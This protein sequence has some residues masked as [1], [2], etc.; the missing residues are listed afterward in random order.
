MSMLRQA[1]IIASGVW[2]GSQT[3]L[4]NRDRNYDVKLWVVH[5]VRDDIEIAYVLD[6]VTGWS[7]GLNEYGIGVVNTALQVKRDEAEKQLANK[8]GKKSKDGE[9]ILKTLL[10]KTLDSAVKVACTFKGGIKGHTFIS[11]LKKTVSIEATTE[12][13]HI[14]KTLSNTKI[15]IRTNH[16]FHYEDAGY[17]HDSDNYHSSVARRDKAIEVLRGLGSPAEIGPALMNNRPKDRNDPNAIVRDTDNMRTSSQMVLDLT[18]KTLLLNLIPEKVEFLGLKDKMPKG[19]TPKI[20]IKVFKYTDVDGDGDV[21]QIE[22]TKMASIE[23]Q[24]QLKTNLLVHKKEIPLCYKLLKKEIEL[25]KTRP[26]DGD[27]TM[28]TVKEANWVDDLISF[29]KGLSPDSKVYVI[30][31]LLT[32]LPA[33][34]SAIAYLLNAITRMIGTTWKIIAEWLNGRAKGE[35]RVPGEEARLKAAI[36]KMPDKEQ[37]ALFKMLTIAYTKAGVPPQKIM[38]I[39]Q[40]AAA[41]TASTGG[42]MS[43]KT[44]ALDR[45]IE[46]LEEDG[47]YEAVAQARRLQ[48]RY[49]A[50]AVGIPK[51][52][53]ADLERCVK[54][55]KDYEGCAGELNAIWS[56]KGGMKLEQKQY[57]AMCGKCKEGAVHTAADEGT[58]VHKAIH[59]TLKSC[60][61]AG[62]SF[63]ECKK[64]VATLPHDMELTQDDYND[65]KK[66]L[67]QASVV[68]AASYQECFKSMMAEMGV[69]SPGELDDEQSKDFFSKVKEQ[70][71]KEGE[72]P[73]ELEAAVIEVEARMSKQQQK[74]M[75]GPKGKK[76]RGKTVWL[77]AERPKRVRTRGGQAWAC[78]MLYVKMPTKHLGIMKRIVGRGS[79]AP[80]KIMMGGKALRIVGDI[81]KEY[82]K[83][84]K[85]YKKAP[86]PAKKAPA[87]KTKKAAGTLPAT[88]G[89]NSPATQKSNHGSLG[90]APIT[91]QS[92]YDLLA[93]PTLNDKLR[94]LKTKRDEA[95]RLGKD[96]LVQSIDAV[97]MKALQK[98]GSSN[99]VVVGE[100]G[101][102]QLVEAGALDKVKE[103]LG[104][105]NRLEFMGFN[106]PPKQFN[107]EL[108]KRSHWMKGWTI[109]D[110]KDLLVPVKPAS[111]YG[112]VFA[113]VYKVYLAGVIF[114]LSFGAAA[115]LPL[116]ATDLVIIGVV[117]GLMPMSPKN[118]KKFMAFV[119]KAFLTANPGRK[120]KAV[121][122]SAMQ[123]LNAIAMHPDTQT[124]AIYA[125]GTDMDPWKG[126]ERPAVAS[127]EVNALVFDVLA[128]KKAKV[129]FNHLRSKGTEALKTEYLRARMQFLTYRKPGNKYY[130]I[131]FRRLCTEAKYPVDDWDKE[132][133]NISSVEEQLLKKVLQGSVDPLLEDEEYFMEVHTAV[134]LDENF[135]VLAKRRPI[136][137]TKTK[138]S[139]KWLFCE[140]PIK[141]KTRK[142]KAYWA[143]NCHYK[144]SGKSEKVLQI[145]L[146]AKKP[147][148]VEVDGKR[149]PIKKPKK[150]NAPAKKTAS[151]EDAFKRLTE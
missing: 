53:Y 142:G 113:N 94:A 100:N 145:N 65:M 63:A 44:A 133:G 120:H 64:A 4:K 33:M 48:E 131:E 54:A 101:E 60:V 146:G 14:T 108:R 42:T 129:I 8:P 138:K 51:R 144:I 28:A 118:A 141:K 41:K 59:K 38:R 136:M 43:I 58:G 143:S 126:Y 80:R 40:K 148:H 96:D 12:H 89:K 147:Q 114:T 32:L 78:K 27:W 85:K 105:A 149:V 127:T 20:A 2:G 35:E 99:I 91:E 73:S 9:R 107:K 17:A 21:D 50:D 66:Q 103:I 18:N 130:F 24:K 3:L 47:K 77:A 98:H 137:R 7:E 87:K 92:N 49:A 116:L 70:C 84:A 31:A 122:A 72:I 102:V 11:D 26:E 16:G 56:E 124:I 115:F 75:F 71:S 90:K 25:E 151:V 112:R 125:A 121:I 74:K 34:L 69:K 62:K 97:M 1:C 30:I 22:V 93:E 135:E 110:L 39:C 61:E 109:D 95:A 150:V 15:H 134:A 6:D 81:S 37:T 76:K 88:H 86:A 67:K 132:Q 104:R 123:H 23:K 139:K 13:K 140:P 57:D 52:M 19:R 55:G 106:I 83:M 45:A 117:L 111:D 36:K 82:A 68:Y 29:W 46:L 128:N 119:V 5:E 79:Q 10:E